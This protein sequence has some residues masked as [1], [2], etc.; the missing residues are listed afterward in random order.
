MDAA[1]RAMCLDDPFN[2]FI[3]TTLQ[4]AGILVISHFFHILLKPLGQPG[5]VAQI[6]AGIVLGPSLL[7]HIKIVKEFFLQSS[8]ADYYDVFSS[9]YGILFMFLI[10]LEM[11]VPYLKRNL[12]KAVIVAYGGIVVCSI[13]GLAASFFVIRILKLTANTASLANVIMIV[14]ANSASPVVIRLAA[15][16]KFSTSDTGRLATCS[17]IINEMSCLLWLSLIVVFMSWKMFGMAVLFFVLTVGLVFVNKYLAGWCDKRNRNQ[18]YVTNTEMFGILFLVIALS[19]LTEEYGF[20]STMPCFLLGLMFPREGKTTRT[21]TIKLA[22][23]VHNFILP[24]YFGYIGFQFNITYL[25]S[26]RNII[27]VALMT[28]LSM[29]GK[30]IGTLAACHYLSIPTIDGIVLSFLLNLKGHAELLVVGVLKKTILKTWWDQNVHNL[31]VMVVVLNTIIS[32]PIVAYILRKNEKYFS[33]KRNLLEFREPEEEIRML[34]C[35]YGSRHITAKIGLI[36]TLSGSSE[37]PTTPY[38]M[39]LVELPKK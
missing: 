2:P 38:L 24:I 29:G 13:F 15:E 1:R 25:N 31:V 14:L 33:Q 19:F 10:G 18:K 12:K 4:A 39:H 37:T 22:Y 26:S 30:I 20:N 3:S 28:I 8:S 7:S 16:L 36:F 17:S 27:A 11:D 32:G 9:I 35:V 6:L 23:A 21:L 34:A 5:P